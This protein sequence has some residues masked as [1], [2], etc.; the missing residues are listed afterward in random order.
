MT[1]IFQQKIKI[2]NKK[3]IILTKVDIFNLNF[4]NNFDSF[5]KDYKTFE[6]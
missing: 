2:I 4:N 6:R 5:Y 1:T 3:S